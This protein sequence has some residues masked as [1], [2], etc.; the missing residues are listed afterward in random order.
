MSQLMITLLLGSISVSIY[1]LSFYPKQDIFPPYILYVFIALLVVANFFIF[2]VYFNVSF[3]SKWLNLLV[4]S[5][6]R[7]LK[8]YLKV[9]SYFNFYELRNVLLLSLS[10]YFVFSLQFYILLRFFG[11]P[12]SIHEGIFLI[13]L[14]YFVLSAIPSIALAEVGIR[15]SV[16]MGVFDY[17]FNTTLSRNVDYDF[18]V[19]AASSVLWI[20]NL[21][22]PAILGN[23]FVLKLNFFK[24]KKE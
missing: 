10:R 14:V 11:I 12:L 3:I 8:G 6:W 2:S 24:N 18:A 13:S 17:Y 23:F 22:I 19:I 21:A 16:A 4:K 5:K 20:V 7:K 9:F 1:I 15:G